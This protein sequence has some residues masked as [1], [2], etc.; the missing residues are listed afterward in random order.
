MPI[1]FQDMQFGFDFQDIA[2]AF[3]AWQRDY[4]QA[5]DDFRIGYTSVRP[6]P[7]GAN[8]SSIMALLTAARSLNVL[9]LGLQLRRFGF[10]EF[11]ARHTSII[12]AWMKTDPG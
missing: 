6:W 7:T 5:I 8:D 12:T 3:T 9:N 4:P 2:I 1:D 10:E 11:M